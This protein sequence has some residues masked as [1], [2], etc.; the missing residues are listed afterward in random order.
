MDPVLDNHIC[1]QVIIRK[2]IEKNIVTS[3]ELNEDYKKTWEAYAK[4]LKSPPPLWR[5]FWKA[6]LPAR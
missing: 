2:L 1:I 6:L 4:E 3:E 5:R